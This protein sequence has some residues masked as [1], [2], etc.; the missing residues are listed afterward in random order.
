M[1]LVKPFKSEVLMFAD[2]TVVFYVG[3]SAEETESVLNT[4]LENVFRCCIKND[5]IVN[6]RK[7]KQKHCYLAPEEGLTRYM[8][9]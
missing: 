3:K 7:G 6:L 2:D 8:V 1:T 9:N 5:L 4:E